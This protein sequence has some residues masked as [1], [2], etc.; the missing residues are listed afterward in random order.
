MIIFFIERERENNSDDG[1]MQIDAFIS[2]NKRR[3]K[4]K[5]EYRYI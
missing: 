3:R 2:E 4:K 5:L 1:T